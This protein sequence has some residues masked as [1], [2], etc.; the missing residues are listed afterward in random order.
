MKLGG[1][2]GDYSTEESSSNED[3]NCDDDSFNFEDIPLTSG[4]QLGTIMI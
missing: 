4:T 1:I 3:L 2:T